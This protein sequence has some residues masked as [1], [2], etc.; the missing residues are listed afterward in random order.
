MT[1]LKQARDVFSYN[2]GRLMNSLSHEAIK[3]DE[4]TERLKKNP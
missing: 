1:A 2:T 3:Q 4:Y